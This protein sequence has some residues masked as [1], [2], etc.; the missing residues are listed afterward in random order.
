M[1]GFWQGRSVSIA[2]TRK[3]VVATASRREGVYNRTGE[4]SV[5]FCGKGGAR[6][7]ADGFFFAVGKKEAGAKRTLLRRGRSG[8][9]RTHGI[10]LPKHARYQLRYTP[11]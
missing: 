4:P 7:R 8:G 3:R 10:M 5:P 11:M 1:T 2:G 9:I 6:E